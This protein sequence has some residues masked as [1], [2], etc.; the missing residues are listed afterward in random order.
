MHPRYVLARYFVGKLVQS[1]LDY[2]INLDGENIEEISAL[3][4]KHQYDY[5]FNE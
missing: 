4:K 2:C 1:S 3:C 5:S